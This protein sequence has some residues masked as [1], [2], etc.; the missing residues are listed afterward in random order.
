MTR[1]FLKIVTQGKI[2]GKVYYRSVI[3]SMIFHQEL[4]TKSKHAIVQDSRKWTLTHSKVGLS[5]HLAVKLRNSTPLLKIRTKQNSVP[6]VLGRY[7]MEK[8]L[9][10]GKFGENAALGTKVHIF[11]VLGKLSLELE[12]PGSWTSHSCAKKKIMLSFLLPSCP[13][14]QAHKYLINGFQK[15]STNLESI[16]KLLS[17]HQFNHTTSITLIL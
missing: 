2:K 13:T 10:R 11:G 12:A 1:L 3:T 8:G 5:T 17:N 6:K 9:E 14:T 7:A 4:Y 15:F 16:V